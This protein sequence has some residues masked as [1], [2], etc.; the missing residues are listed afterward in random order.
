MVH[1]TRAALLASMVGL[2]GCIIQFDAQ[3]EYVLEFGVGDH[4]AVRFE[5]L[6]GDV[7]LRGM[8]TDLARL[9]GT[10]RAVG[11]T[12]EKARRNLEQARL[13]RESAGDAIILELD[14]PLELIGLVDLTLDRVSTLP[15]GLDVIIAVEDGDVLVE[16]MR[17]ALDLRTDAG[18]IEVAEGEGAL[19][20]VAGSGE[21]RAESA[22]PMTITAGEG[23]DVAATTESD[24]EV[25]ITTT[26]GAVVLSMPPGQGFRLSCRPG[27][28]TV[29]VDPVFGAEIESEEGGTVVYAAG[30]EARIIE[31][32]T[33][34]GDV[35]VAPIA[36]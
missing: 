30:D 4:G 19:L 35:R 21:V 31:I 8:G 34:G 24:R 20:A 27:E 15:E 16:G 36:E 1:L 26:G 14:I 13:A 10:R 25:S 28:G 7:D 23:A 32:R 2:S 11:A 33:D 18:D 17:G 12:K 6:D 22:G 5:G 3:D 9:R 29:E